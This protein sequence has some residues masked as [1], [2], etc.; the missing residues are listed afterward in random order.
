MQEGCYTFANCMTKAS[1]LHKIL[2]L[3]LLSAIGPFSIDMYLPAFNSM[4]ESLNTDVAQIQLSLTSFFVGVASGQL[5][6]GPLLDRFGRKNPLLAGL[7]IYILASIGCALAQSSDQLIVLRFIQ[8]IG[9][10]SGMVAS[11]ALVRDYFK[12]QE[13]AKILSL[14]MLVIGISPIL[15]PTI[16]GYFISHF[17]WNAIF[18]LL[19]IIVFLILLVVLFFL[20]EKQRTD[21]VSSLKPKTVWL[22]FQTVFKTPQFYIN[23]FAGGIASSG[24]YAYLAGSSYVMMNVFHT[25]E[26]QYGWIFALIAAALV[27]SSQ[28]NSFLLKTYTS[29][30]IATTALLIQSLTGLLMFAITVNGSMTLTGIIFLLFIFLGCQGFTFPNTSAGALNPFS[31][32]AGSASALLGSIQLAIGA[33]SSALVSALHDGTAIPMTGVMTSCAIIGVLILKLGRSKIANE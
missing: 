31:K 25:S 9:S 18:Y 12:P 3:G 24:L 5:I 1:A 15:A 29:Y 26:K 16:G 13:T 2:L 20:P 27:I 17:G 4:A 28:L 11:R 21:S 7:V 19:S 22:A 32:L 14:L 6:Y 10:C 8:A 23:A 30:R 33:I